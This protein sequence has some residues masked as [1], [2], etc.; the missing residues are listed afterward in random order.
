MWVIEIIWVLLQLGMTMGIALI[1]AICGIG[2]LVKV[3]DVVIHLLEGDFPKR[4]RELRLKFSDFEK[5]YAIN[6]SRYKIEQWS[7]WV[8]FHKEDVLRPTRKY[9][10]RFGPI[11]YVRFLIWKSAHQDTDLMES[12]LESVQEDIANK[13]AEAERRRMEAVELLYQVHIREEELKWPEE[14]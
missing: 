13:R 4:Q 12:Y 8:L 5:Y 6:P 10:I 2:I 14:N 11:D 7:A 1:L 3:V 9:K